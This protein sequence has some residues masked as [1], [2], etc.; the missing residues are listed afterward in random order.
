MTA[1]V[2]ACPMWY[3]SCLLISGERVSFKHRNCVGRRLQFWGCSTELRSAPGNCRF[4]GGAGRNADG[5]RGRGCEALRRCRCCSPARMHECDAFRPAV[6]RLRLLPGLRHRCEMMSCLGPQALARAGAL[7]GVCP[8][9]QA[10]CTL[11]KSHGFCRGVCVWVAMHKVPTDECAMSGP[12]L[13]SRAYAL[14]QS[15]SPS[16]TTAPRVAKWCSPAYG[17]LR[18]ISEQHMNSD[19]CSVGPAHAASQRS[20]HCHGSCIRIPVAFL[21]GYPVNCQQQIPPV[22]VASALS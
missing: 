22:P 7:S 15:L 19:S 8:R 11:M 9:G 3:G 18:G 14:S 16:S 6:D 10:D 13:A 5:G 1:V 21:S 2:V 4:C 17:R 20:V 12:Q